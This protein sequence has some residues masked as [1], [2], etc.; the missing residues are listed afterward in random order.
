MIGRHA[1]PLLPGWQ[2]VG[3][4]DTSAGAGGCA[5]AIITPV[6][7]GFRG[8]GTDAIR[9]HR[10]AAHNGN[11]GIIHRRIIIDGVGRIVGRIGI[12]ITRRIEVR[13]PLRGKLLED[14]LGPRVKLAPGPGGA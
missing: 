4:A 9:G 14:L 2:G 3:G 13:L 8:P 12:T 11:V 7:G 6:P 5:V 1:D 10:G